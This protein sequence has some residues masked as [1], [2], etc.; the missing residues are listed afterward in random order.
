MTSPSLSS[1]FA[2]SRP[3][4]DGWPGRALRRSERFAGGS[5]P[6]RA[7][8]RRS[9]DGVDLAPHSTGPSRALAAAALSV[10]LCG[11]EWLAPPEALAQTAPARVFGTY[12]TP[13]AAFSPWYMQPVAPVLGD[14]SIPTSN[15]Y[16]TVA[17]GTWSTGVFKA[18]SSDPSVT[19]YP[20]VG[21]T[22]GIWDPDAEGYRPTVVI[23]RWPANVVPASG[24]DGHADIIDEAMGIVHSFFQ[25]R[26]E[27][28]TWRASQYAW[29]PLAGRGF[30][31]GGHYY[32]GARAVG[33]PAI[34]GVIRKAEVNDGL[35]WY[36]HALAISLT[37]NALSAATTYIYPA[38]SAD[39]NA[40]TTN[41]G[42]IPQGS[43]L[44]LPPTFDTSTL[45]NL[46]LRK[47]AE[48]LKRYGGYVVDRNYGTPFVIYAENGSNFNL[49]P[50]GWD[51]TTANELQAVRAALR[52][53]M[54]VSG[55]VDG[56]GVSIIPEQRLNILSLRGQWNL[57]RSSPLGTF[58]TWKQAVVFP[59]TAV[60]VIQVNYSLRTISNVAWAKPVAGTPY[61]LTARTSGGGRLRLALYDNSGSKLYDSGELS[62]GN[63][64]SFSWPAN[65]GR[66]AVYAYSGN[67]GTTSS[68]GGTLISDAPLT[69]MSGKTLMK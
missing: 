41:T 45:T 32:Q 66:V 23:P 65:Y 11:T 24:S 7:G 63:V 42:G 58:D 26:L 20:L 55:W 54:S 53:V 44:M 6:S 51:N 46:K 49:M 4:P 67:A 29:A 47:V 34:G 9:A 68:V 59:A 50:N 39:S 30:G 36:R 64:A 28:G 48:T 40:A 2:S 43:L 21:N 38:T 3:I 12:D 17:E 18:L 33:V 27:N 22:S 60:D 13:F 57:Q 5:P 1:L 16:P 61:K 31:E 10:M 62:D 14:F 52:Q 69:P 35:G 19:V 15:Y 8:V 56:N 25:L 37:Y